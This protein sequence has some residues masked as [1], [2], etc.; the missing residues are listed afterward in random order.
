MRR[1][2]S[3]LERIAMKYG[4]R[5]TASVYVA[6]GWV[7]AACG[8][9]T[10]TPSGSGSSSDSGTSSEIDASTADSGSQSGDGGACVDIDLAT[11][12][13]SCQS[14]TD[15]INVN[16]GSICSGYTCLCGGHAI[17]VDGEAR[18]EAALSSVSPGPGPLC[19]CPALGRPRCVQTQCVY[20]PSFSGTAGPPGCPDGG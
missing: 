9:A 8:G 3:L 11:Y 7:A 12:D 1:A 19:E 18:Y 4:A 17:N 13:T 14:D 2:R 15:C 10:S 5:L 16:A 20:C 6:I